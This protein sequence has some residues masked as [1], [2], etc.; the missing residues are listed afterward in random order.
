[1]IYDLFSKSE[2]GLTQML[3]IL[4]GYCD[5]GMYFNSDVATTLSL[6]DATIKPILLYL[7]DFWGCMNMPKSNPLENLHM[8]ICKQIL[9][10]QKQTTNIGVLLELG[11]VPLQFHAIKSAIK[12]WERIQKKQANDILLASYRDALVENL[13]WVSRI[14]DI[15]E[16][17]GM[18]TF[19]QNNYE[20]KHPF[21]NKKLFL[22]LCDTF[23]Q[24]SFESIRSENSKLRS[25]ALFKKDIGYE[26][27]LSEI[28]NTSAR[29]QMTKLRLS[30]HSL[31]IEVGRFTNI[32][33][34]MRFCPFCRETVETEVHFL[35]NCPT[36]KFL[37][38]KFLNP[39]Y[40]INP[41]FNLFTEEQ[42]FEY[43]MC[44]VDI[45]LVNYVHSSFQLRSF[46]TSNPKRLI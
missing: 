37:R 33:K 38:L 2:K 24:N 21:I 36:Y 31:M 28:K 12:N 34:E 35:L 10:V 17:N 44:T 41:G 7:S 11:R 1:M 40:R 39:I 15:L 42:K 5:L 20:N 9:G 3:K 14:K 46:L 30:N 43:I 32:P 8:L 18:L 27:Y 25:Y 19:F 23:H 29:I 4:E 6:F 13:P 16:K 22:R 45:N 26:Q